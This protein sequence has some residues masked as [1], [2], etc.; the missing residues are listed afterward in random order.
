MQRRGCLRLACLSGAL[1]AWVGCASSGP[2]GESA[3]T[4]VGRIPTHSAPAEDAV[5]A[6]AASMPEPGAAEAPE[7]AAPPATHSALRPIPPNTAV[8]H[9]GDSFVLAG[10]SQALKPRMKAIGA[11]YEVRSEQS[12]YT[13]T[14]A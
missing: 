10:F 6:P 11:R 3:R 5:T 8:L 9:I 14:W 12:S 7:P 1:V 13:V 4:S 2:Q